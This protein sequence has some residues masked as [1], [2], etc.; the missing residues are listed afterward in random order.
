ME[1]VGCSWRGA[2][3]ADDHALH[4]KRLR[5]APEHFLPRARG[6]VHEE[7]RRG[8]HLRPAPLE[9]HP[10]PHRR[11]EAV[12]NV[13][14]G[15]RP[16]DARLVGHELSALRRLHA[17]RPEVLGQFGCFLPEGGD[18]LLAPKHGGDT[19]DGVAHQAQVG[20]DRDDRKNHLGL[21]D[22]VDVP[23]ADRRDRRK[24]PRQTLEVARPQRLG[25]EIDR[26]VRDPGVG[27]EVPAPREQVKQASL[28]VARQQ[29][30]DQ[31]VRHD[32]HPVRQPDERAKFLQRRPAPP[33][34]EH[35]QQPE[36][37]AGVER[38]ATARERV[39]GDQAGRPAHVLEPVPLQ[40]PAPAQRLV[41]RPDEREQHHVAPR[42][43]VEAPGQRVGARRRVAAEGEPQRRERDGGQRDGCRREPVAAV[44]L[45]LGVD[46]PF[47]LRW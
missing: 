3:A 13:R 24:G 19:R 37:A 20:H 9:Q 43:H 2:D 5:R 44:P 42:K 34:P 22:G 1:H 16:E 26:V 8:E 21:R 38:P 36:Q 46:G 47:L 31:V 32:A 29:V 18:L 30:E 12:Q 15:G 45:R 17:V 7:A 35:A 6:H 4:I 27:R 28:G 11:R 40:P 10:R 25:V 41:R 39:E 14:R 33:E 23:V